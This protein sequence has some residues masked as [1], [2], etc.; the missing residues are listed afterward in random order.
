M[1]VTSSCRKWP[2][3]DC[4]DG[5]ADARAAEDGRTLRKNRLPVGGRNGTD[6]T[7]APP[8]ACSSPS[9][10]ACGRRLRTAV[11]LGAYSHREGLSVPRS[12]PRLFDVQ[13]LRPDTALCQSRRRAFR[14]LAALMRARVC[15][16]GS[17][18]PESR[19]TR[20]A[21]WGTCRNTPAWPL[22]AL[23]RPGGAAC[24][25]HRH[26]PMH[27]RGPGWRRSCGRGCAGAAV[28]PFG[29]ELEPNGRH[30]RVLRI[31][32]ALGLRGKGGAYFTQVAYF[33]KR[34][35]LSYRLYSPGCRY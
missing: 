32:I 18:A 11:P 5:E 31:C 19:H 33:A 1:Y 10:G 20:H 9:V 17:R 22:G 15:G 2:H 25:V 23:A 26:P 34:P 7:R 8:G 27:D 30:I 3:A 35:G 4:S 16:G 13:V 12:A 28:A 29:Y 24:V 21:R 14:W 6:S